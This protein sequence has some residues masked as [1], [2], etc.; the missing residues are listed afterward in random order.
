M[1]STEK[2]TLYAQCHCKRQTFEFEIDSDQ[3]PIQTELCHCDDCRKVTGLLGND[4]LMVRELL[5]KDLFDINNP[6]K[7]LRSFTPLRV[8]WWFCDE[9]GCHLVQHSQRS[10]IEAKNAK[11]KGSEAKYNWYVFSGI[12][13][14]DR[15][16]NGS[17]V[18]ERRKHSWVRPGRD[19]GGLARFMP[20]GLP[21][22]AGTDNSKPIPYSDTFTEDKPEFQPTKEE[23]EAIEKAIKADRLPLRCACGYVRLSIKRPIEIGC[24]EKFKRLRSPDEQKWQFKICPCNS[25]RT[26]SGFEGATGL[27]FPSL[28]HIERLEAEKDAPKPVGYSKE[29][30]Q[31]DPQKP[32]TI[33]LA[34]YYSS[35]NNARRFC[36]NCGASVWIDF[37]DVGKAVAS[38]YMGLLDIP[39]SFFPSQSKHPAPFGHD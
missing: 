18:W 30:L 4:F 34:T 29:K 22:Y 39:V 11:Q 9:C 23:Q 5:Q 7:G 12:T 16:Q 32:N 15:L 10:E 38:T 20:D 36:P 26:T 35:E 6:P 8:T 13:Y 17:R 2:V 37:K 27:F 31:G 21:R 3:F 25:C 1:S 14:P 33:G 28:D 19:L 24:E